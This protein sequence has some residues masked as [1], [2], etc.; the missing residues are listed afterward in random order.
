MEA[1]KSQKSENY[2]LVNINVIRPAVFA[3]WHLSKLGSYL[4][5]E[6][7]KKRP[8][9]PSDHISKEWFSVP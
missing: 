3:S 4:P 1:Q 9:L 6:T 8:M 5:T 7:R 2:G